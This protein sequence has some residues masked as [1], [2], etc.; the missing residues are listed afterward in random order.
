MTGWRRFRTRSARFGAVFTSA[1]RVVIKH[2]RYRE[3][4]RPLDPACPCY[5]C[6]RFSRAYLRHLFTSNEMLGSRLMTLHNL[7]FYQRLMARLRNAVETGPEALAA[8]RVEAGRSMTA[9]T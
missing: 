7:S 2:A 9:E 5:T 3:D 4:A 6:A 8:L 1:G